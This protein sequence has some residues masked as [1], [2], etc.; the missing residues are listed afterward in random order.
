MYSSLYPS[1]A[2][3]GFV[4]DW[5]TGVRYL[6]R[7]GRED[8][9]AAAVD[10]V[11]S[12]TVF[13]T[14]LGTQYTA[15]KLLSLLERLESRQAEY[16]ERLALLERR[17][18]RLDRVDPAAANALRSQFASAY[19]QKMAELNAIRQ[20]AQGLTGR[21]RTYA[22]SVSKQSFQ[23]A[24]GGGP[25]APAV[26]AVPAVTVA[27]AATV[28]LGVIYLLLQGVNLYISRAEAAE[29]EA[30]RQR[31]LAHGLTPAQA[32]KLVQKNREARSKER[33][34]KFDPLKAITGAIPWVAAIV[35]TV[36]LAPIAAPVVAGLFKKN[37]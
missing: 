6:L 1:A 18:D 13:A 30:I 17:F 22:I 16:K 7:V 31:A 36:Y 5:V 34:G 4:D 24:F 20:H 23:G 8:G 15:E 25:A 21:A 27:A 14:A 32:E 35:L 10:E 28:A 29:D 2:Y 12:A 26:A 11:G 9:V 3:G 37:A 33:A 19:G